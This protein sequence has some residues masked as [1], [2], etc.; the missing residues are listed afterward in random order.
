VATTDQ[1]LQTQAG[2]AEQIEGG[3]AECLDLAPRSGM[4]TAG[5]KGGNH[6]GQ[7]GR[8]LRLDP[9]RAGRYVPLQRGRGD[10]PSFRAFLL[11]PEPEAR[12]DAHGLRRRPSRSST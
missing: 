1:S 10:A 9:G 5:T 4:A 8:R 11:W 3:S 7:G 2:A 12:P 6:P